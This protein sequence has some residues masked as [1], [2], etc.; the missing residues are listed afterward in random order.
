MNRYIT[1]GIAALCLANTVAAANSGIELK[2]STLGLGI[3]FAH[4]FNDYI[5]ARVG[6]NNFSYHYNDTQG[7]VDYNMDFKLRSYDALV[8]W[9]PFGGS[10]RVTGGLVHNSNRVHGTA[11]SAN[12]Y[13]IGTTTYTPAEIGTLTG[14]V[15][16]DP[17]A[18][19]LGFG[20]G[21]SP[22]DTGFGTSIDFGVVRQGTPQ[23]SLVAEGGT[24]VSDPQFQ[25]DL[26]QEQQQFQSDANSFRTYPV[27]S[28]GVNYRF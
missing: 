25:S 26:A 22:A 24:L 14:D 8:D 28:I 19:Y 21:M 5:G 11:A 10:F 1:A 15:Q 7:G 13:T 20:W 23:T 3:E 27:V 6:F 4:N 9:R 12:S 2:A 17:T 16:F 18:P